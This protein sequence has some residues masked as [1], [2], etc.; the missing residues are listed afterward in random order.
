MVTVLRCGGL[1]GLL[2]LGGVY[3]LTSL[4]K[5]DIMLAPPGVNFTMRNVPH[6]FVNHGGDRGK[7]VC[8]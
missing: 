7:I 5:I 8:D 6:L 3:N 4:P 2:H 1:T